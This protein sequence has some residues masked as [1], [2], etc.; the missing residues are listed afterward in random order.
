MLPK[1]AH[2]QAVLHPEELNVADRSRT[3]KQP[4]CYETRAEAHRVK[5]QVGLLNTPLEKRASSPLQ[6]RDD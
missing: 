1:H 4:S 5:P 2:Y 6:P 3:L